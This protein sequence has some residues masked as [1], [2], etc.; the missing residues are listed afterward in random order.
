MPILLIKK[1]KR[2]LFWAEMLFFR[3][4]SV[5]L[6]LFPPSRTLPLPP[7]SPPPLLLLYTRVK[8]SPGNTCKTL[9]IMLNVD[10]ERREI[11]T[12]SAARRAGLRVARQGETLS[13]GYHGVVLGWCSV[14]VITMQTVSQGC[15]GVV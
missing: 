9:Q 2:C 8:I 4:S 1:R 13:L 15:H 5:P 10:G 14:V 7:P 11:L 12:L 3:L 6:H